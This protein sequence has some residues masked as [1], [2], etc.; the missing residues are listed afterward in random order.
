MFTLDV[1]EAE[2][3]LGVIN[4]YGG[5]FHNFDPANHTTD[6][7]YT[8]KVMDG[9]HSIKVGD[10]YVVSK[11]T[12][13][14]DAAVAPTCTA[15]G[16]TEGKHCS[17][18]GEVLVAQTV[19][20]A[21]GHD[22]VNHEAKAPTCTEIGWDAY[23]TCSRCDYTTY[24]E[25]AKLGHDYVAGNVVAP[26]CEAQG[27]TIYDCSRCD[28][29]ENRNYVA[30]TGHTLP[31][32]WTV[33]TAPT[34]AE[35]GS[36]KRECT[37]CDYVE[38][39]DLDMI[40]HTPAEAVEENRV[41][42]TCT[43][44]G[45]YDNVVYCT[46][47]NAELSRETITVEAKGH[48]E[49]IDNAVAPT[50]VATGL[51]KG[52][53]CSVCNEVLVAQEK[54]DALGHNIVDDKCT[55]CGLTY[56]NTTETISFADTTQRVSLSNDSQVWKS[57]HVTF[58]N[59]KG[60]S[61]SSVADHSN[62]VRLYKYSTVNISAPKNNKIVINSST[63]E[64]FTNLQA[65]IKE[66]DGY[67]ISVSGSKIT[68]EFNSSVDSFEFTCS[69]GQC[70]FISVVVTYKISSCSHVNY[71]EVTPEVPATCTANGTTAVNRCNS[72]GEEF[73]GETIL[74]S[75]DMGEWT[76]TKA[77]TCTTAGERTR[78]C[79]RADCDH[80]E[81]ETIDATGHNYVDGVCTVC[82]AEKPSGETPAEPTVVLEITKDDFNGTSYAANNNEKTEGDYSYTSYQVMKQ[83]DTMQ[84]Q[85]SKGYITITSNEFVKLEL[86][87]TAGTY[88][89]TVGGTTVT[90]TTSNGVTTYDLSG[91]TGEIKISVGSALGNTEYLKFYK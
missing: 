23:V 64:Y 30:A 24:A 47:C 77:A 86:K 75:H 65:S 16:L 66:N 90:G 27:Y 57:E 3:V 63:G 81:T 44:A 50:C 48:T 74:A 68:I 29:T 84:W 15:T 21:L 10:N 52:K 87:V 25:K 18:C 91:F 28:A 62:P 60:S 6:G 80:A 83:S 53:H 59:N 40:A 19:V 32:E 67:T 49:V 56:T 70:R 13:V 36:A 88:T 58:T 72:C 55:V 61:T 73:G 69:G 79:N 9:Y 43:E 82:S 76:T 34:C 7:T 26:K 38:T 37:S 39:K 11:H 71:T 17:V 4:V 41:E 22:E 12:E 14:V 2:A 46:V 85:K 33:V 78:S 1:N 51:T 54:V 20:D 31:E 89:V 5:T 45:S 35:K 42:A 8:N